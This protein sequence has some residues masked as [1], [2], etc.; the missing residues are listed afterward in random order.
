MEQARQGTLEAR[1][2]LTLNQLG[3]SRAPDEDEV[4]PSGQAVGEGPKGVAH[5]SLHLVAI[6]RAPDL[7]ANRHPQANIIAGLSGERVEH[8]VAVRLR[9]A[10]P[11]GA[12]EIAAAGEAAPLATLA[13]GLAVASHPI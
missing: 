11:V 7:S 10:I 3:D 5:G 8:E 13:P 12:V 4:V 9:S 1:R 6:N 2:S